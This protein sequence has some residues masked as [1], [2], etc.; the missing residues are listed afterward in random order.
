MNY[1]KRKTVFAIC[2]FYII[3]I[4]VRYIATKTNI[5]SDTNLYLKMIARGIGPI[6]GV[7]VACFIFKLKFSPM[8]L[9]GNYKFLVFPTLVYWIVPILLFSLWTTTTQGSFPFF[10]VFMIFVYGLLEEI[11]WRGFLQQQLQ[12]LPKIWNILIVGTLWFVWHL[13]FDLT[14]TNLLF[15]GLL[16]FGAWGIGVVANT[17]KSLLAVAA[18]HSLNNVK[19]ENNLPLIALLFV[20]WIVMIVYMEKEKKK[21]ITNQNCSLRASKN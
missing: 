8:T 3:A 18:F 1:S 17:T 16:I 4:S 10:Y 2:V 6:L 12:G 11:G 15:L 20:L 14:T 5:L 21:K 7:I 13:N 19:S 9:K